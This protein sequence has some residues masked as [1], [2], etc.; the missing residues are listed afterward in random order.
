MGMLI[1]CIHGRGALNKQSLM[2]IK[3]TQF[4][5]RCGKISKHG[6]KARALPSSRIFATKSTIGSSEIISESIDNEN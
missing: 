5:L 4:A 3:N 6:V 1:P 2:A